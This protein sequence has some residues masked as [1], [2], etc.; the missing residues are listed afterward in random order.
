M[1]FDNFLSPFKSLFT[2]KTLKID[3]IF[4][5][6][7]FILL[8]VA[9][10][11]GPAIPDIFL[12][13][14]AIY[15]L[16]KSSFNRMW[17]YYKNPIFLGFILFCLYGVLR[18]FFYESPIDSIS[19]E[20][21]IF[22]FR[23]IFFALGIWYLLE[24]NPYLSKCILYV[25]I[26]SILF[27]C[28]DG[29]FQYFNGVN[30]FG[31]EKW[32]NQRLTGVFGDE[33]IIGRYIAFLSLFVFVL[34]Y[35]NFKIKNST[36]FFSIS[37]MIIC[38]VVT[39]LTGERAPLLYVTL[40]SIL[41]IIFMP[42]LRLYRIMGVL[43]SIIIIFAIIQI[44]PNAKNRMIDVTINQVSE[45]QLPFLPYS[46]HHE[47]HYIS[48]IRMFADNP[49]FGIG[50]NTFSFECDKPEYKISERSCTTHP[51]QFFIQVLAELGIFGFL[52]IF[53]FYLYLSW[54]LLKQ[55]LS[56]I[57]KKN[58]QIISFESFLFHIIIFV[59][60]W[61]IIPHMSLYNN[62]NN[63]LMMLPLGF[64]MRAKFGNK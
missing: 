42:Y 1:F 61:P 15:F 45:T 36:I 10:I 27:V 16:I 40:F 12:S 24:N 19:R 62:W 11:T 33:P 55:F 48:A 21:S 49:L 13:L 52:F 37:F 34:L 23:Y 57:L 39:F 17:S 4:F 9:L 51:H 50:T 6:L 29:V 7:L 43:T 44:N 14:I 25:S 26:I 63:V 8:P 60:W 64:Y 47:E 18:S 41:I 38:E 20:G 30:F 3:V 53:S 5:S 2:D 32:S 35:Q 54:S 31:N 28:I 56:I 59:Y 58:D 46:S 22:Y